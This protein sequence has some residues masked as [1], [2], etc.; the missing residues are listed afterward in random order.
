MPYKC[1]NCNEEAHSILSICLNGRKM[2][3]GVDHAE[4]IQT[5]D[6]LTLDSDAMGL[7]DESITAML[8][9]KFW[10]HKS[11]YSVVKRYLQ[12]VHC[13]AML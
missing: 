7:N 8:Y 11:H 9:R 2:K 13:R 1:Q 6:R 5:R 4:T 3:L 12:C 10:K